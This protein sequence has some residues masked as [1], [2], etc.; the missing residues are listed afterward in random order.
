MTAET[1]TFTVARGPREDGM[2]TMKITDPIDGSVTT[3]ARD[4]V[5]GG[6]WFHHYGPTVL[7]G[8]AMIRDFLDAEVEARQEEIARVLGDTYT[9]MEGI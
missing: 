8:I 9:G 7:G 3:Y 2:P 5:A 6:P 1:Y 4:T